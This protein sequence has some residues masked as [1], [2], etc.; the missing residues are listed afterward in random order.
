MKRG[1]MIFFSVMRTKSE[2]VTC[3]IPHLHLVN[4]QMVT[5]NQM[6]IIVTAPTSC[7]HSSSNSLAIVE[8]DQAGL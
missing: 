3:L 8:R 2:Y 6:V 4:S 7:H 1:N 5:V